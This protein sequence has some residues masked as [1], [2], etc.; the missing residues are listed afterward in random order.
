MLSNKQLFRIKIIVDCIVFLY[1]QVLLIQ[2]GIVLFH[3][4]ISGITI[5]YRTK[6]NAISIND[7]SGV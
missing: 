3:D 4:V 6:V 2:C 1:F 7:N 5:F